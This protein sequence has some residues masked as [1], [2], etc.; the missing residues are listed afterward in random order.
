MAKSSLAFSSDSRVKKLE[1][2][3]ERAAYRAEV[4]VNFL[5]FFHLRVPVRWS[6]PAMFLN[7]INDVEKG[8]SVEV[9]VSGIDRFDPVFLHQNSRVSIEDQITTDIT[10]DGEYFGG[11]PLMVLSFRQ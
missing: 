7:G 8:K 4:G 2:T 3:Y 11:D 5:A 6:C 1:Q 9:C 10:Y